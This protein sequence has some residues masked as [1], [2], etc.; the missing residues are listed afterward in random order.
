M[1]NILQ[2]SKLN[3][4][5]ATVKPF[6]TQYQLLT[7]LRPF[8]NLWEKEKMQGNQHF[9]YFQQCFLTYQRQE[10]SLSYIYFIICKSY[11]FNMIQTKNL[12]LV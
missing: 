3:R 2:E 9:L 4:H 10:S 5:E 12:M 7:T 6:I 8:E 11:A 1:C